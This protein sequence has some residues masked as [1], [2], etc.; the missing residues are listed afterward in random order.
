[1]ILAFLGG[2]ITGTVFTLSTLLFLRYLDRTE[3]FE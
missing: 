1:M 2:L 3:P